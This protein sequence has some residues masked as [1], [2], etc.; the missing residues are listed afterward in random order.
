MVRIRVPKT[1][2]LIEQEKSMKNESKV[3][4]KRVSE[5]ECV[6]FTLFAVRFFSSSSVTTVSFVATWQWM[7]CDPT[8]CIDAK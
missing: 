6:L 5:N 3:W 1:Q 7:K 8:F 4:Y 2:F